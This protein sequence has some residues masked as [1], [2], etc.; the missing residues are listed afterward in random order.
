METIFMPC[1]KSSFSQV[2]SANM[3]YFHPAGLS[4]LSSWILEEKDW[5]LEP[6][7]SPHVSV[8]ALLWCN[9]KSLAAWRII[10]RLSEK[11]SFSIL[12]KSPEPEIIFFLCLFCFPESGQNQD[13]YN[14]L[15]VWVTMNMC[16]NQQQQNVVCQCWPFPTCFIFLWLHT[17]SVYNTITEPKILSVQDSPELKQLRMFAFTAIETQHFFHQYFGFGVTGIFRLPKWNCFEEEELTALKN[18]TDQGSWNSLQGGA[19][20]PV[21]EPFA[22]PHHHPYDLLKPPVKGPP[23]WPQQTG[24]VLHTR[25]T[26]EIGGICQP[27]QTWSTGRRMLWDAG[28][29]CCR[30]SGFTLCLH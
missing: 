29:A 27:L 12:W 10:S 22:M 8:C 23:P 18:E 5:S 25:S 1:V 14:F 21:Q 13:S 2:A 7:I 3:P 19:Q 9:A 28:C 26:Y 20:L 16:K 15:E 17:H 6:A 4:L 30:V 24:F 11:L